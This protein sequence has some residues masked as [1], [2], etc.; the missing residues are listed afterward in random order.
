MGRFWSQPTGAAYRNHTLIRYGVVGSADISGILLGGK[1]I[2]IEVK[3]GR[4]V[5]EAQ[6]KSFESMIKMFGG[7]YFVARSVEGAIESLKSAA[8]S[9]EV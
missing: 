7:I 2:E 3:T 6:Q 8:A 5:Q 1:R 9:L 4:A